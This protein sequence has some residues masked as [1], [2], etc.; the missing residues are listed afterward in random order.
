VAVDWSA[1]Y[2]T[3]SRI[4]WQTQTLDRQALFWSVRP[5]YVAIDPLVGLEGAITV[6][7]QRQHVPLC[8]AHQQFQLSV[9]VKIGGGK[10]SGV[11]ARAESDRLAVGACNEP[12][13]ETTVAVPR[14][15]EMSL[16]PLFK[17]ARSGRPSWLKSAATIA[18]GRAR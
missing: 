9:T 12:L 17:T 5:V 2:T 14:K 7:L 13:G 15:M 3:R 8:I 1:W 16:L 11:I 6:A 18:T 10:A 4:D